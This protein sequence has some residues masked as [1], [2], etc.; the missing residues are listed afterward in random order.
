M[1]FA[2]TGVPFN[3]PPSRGS[4]VGI[5]GAAPRVG[6]GYPSALPRT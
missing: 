5:V 2:A 1:S 4:P 3:R 6:D